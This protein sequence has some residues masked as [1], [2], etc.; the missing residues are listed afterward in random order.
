[1]IRPFLLVALPFV[2]ALA[3]CTPAE[4]DNDAAPAETPGVR[5]TAAPI[6]SPAG[7]PP[8]AATRMQSEADAED[9][10][11]ASKV[12]PWIGK[13][14]TVPVRS[15]V[16]EATG[17]ETD[18]WIYPD[19]VVTMDFNPKR[20]NVVMEKETDRILSARCG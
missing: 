19:S 12:G 8:E 16:A 18:R 7:A 6:A 17:A 4:S 2:A 10:C 1:M 20:L 3:A 14:A 13:E 11:G 5:E 15:E 9:A